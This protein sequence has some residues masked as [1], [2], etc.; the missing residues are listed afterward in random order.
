MIYTL[1]HK[2]GELEITMMGSF[3]AASNLRVFLQRPGCPEALDD[4]GPIMEKCFDSDT[5]GTLLSDIRALGNDIQPHRTE[6]PA[7]SHKVVELS[8]ET[9]DAFESL[10]L[11]EGQKADSH[12]IVHPRCTIGGLQYTDYTA[13]PDS[14]IFFSPRNSRERVPAII[15]EIF[16]LPFAERDTFLVIQRYLPLVPSEAHPFVQWTDFG[17]GLWS[18]TMSKEIEVIRTSQSVCHA[19]QRKWGPNTFVMR[20]MG[21]VGSCYMYLR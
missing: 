6:V 18:M 2:S 3:C 8:E 10:V 11:S 21:R 1:T 19:N 15:R 17:A 13:G 5:R 20:P 4:C 16:S 14:I 12:V 9:R 7:G